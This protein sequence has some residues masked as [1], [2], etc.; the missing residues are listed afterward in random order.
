MRHSKLLLLLRHHL[1]LLLKSLSGHFDFPLTLRGTRVVFPLPKLF[2]SQ[3]STESEVFLMLLIEIFVDE[4]KGD[5][6]RLELP[7]PDTERGGLRFP[8]VQWTAQRW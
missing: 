3:L 7:D 2:S 8:H 4:F 5:E 6:T 1:S